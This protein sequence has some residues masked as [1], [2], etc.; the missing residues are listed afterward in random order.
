MVYDQRLK[1]ALKDG[2]LLLNQYFMVTLLIPAT[3]YRSMIYLVVVSLAVYP[4]I[5]LN[6]KS[7]SAVVRD[8]KVQLMAY[9]PQCSSWHQ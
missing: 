3:N 9:L 4:N 2:V 1:Q 8:F 7:N 6:L 5:L